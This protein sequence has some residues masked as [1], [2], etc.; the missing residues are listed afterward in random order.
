MMGEETFQ[1][2]KEGNIGGTQMALLKVMSLFVK[3]IPE[4][5]NTQV[6]LAAK[7]DNIPESKAQ[8]F[9][10]Q[11]IAKLPAF[12]QDEAAA[13]RLWKESEERAGIEFKL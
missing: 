2:M 5:A 1:K 13:Q 9:D 10:N 7:A 6:W 4:G 3:E 12:A 11:K 8:Y